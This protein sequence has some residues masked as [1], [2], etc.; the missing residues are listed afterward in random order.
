MAQTGNSPIIS[1]TSGKGGVGK[2]FIACN[3]AASLARE[4][5]RI[6]VADCDLGLANID[7]MLGLRPRR[8]LRDVIY[9]EADLRDVIVRTKGGFDLIPASSGVRE[10]AQLILERIE[11]VKEK[12][13][14]LRGYDLVLLDTG[15]G[16]SEVVL[17]FNLLAGRNIV[18]I[19]RELTSLTDAYAMIKTMY[20]VFDRDSLDIVVNSAADEKEGGE[21]FRHISS[22]CRKF[23]NVKL[24]YLGHVVQDGIVPKSILRQE[25]AVIASPRSKIAANFQHIARALAT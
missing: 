11:T 17:Q 2:T 24:T 12:I 6:L 4:G 3:L 19:N 5:K 20:Q 9:G 22:I 14:S 18:V 16:I 13:R 23:L 7:V 10:M 15:S 21:I 25:I 1:I 8:N